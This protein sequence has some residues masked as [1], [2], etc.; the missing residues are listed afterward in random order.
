VA[1]AFRR[2]RRVIDGEHAIANLAKQ[3][4][5]LRPV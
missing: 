1:T 4:G 2:E 5:L 3:S